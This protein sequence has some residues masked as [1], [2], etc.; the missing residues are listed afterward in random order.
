MLNVLFAA[1]FERGQ[2]LCQIDELIAF[3]TEA[4]LD[5]TDTRKAMQTGQ[6]ATVA[7]ADREPLAAPR[8]WECKHP[9]PRVPDPEVGAPGADRIT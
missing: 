2:D 4:G 6:Y 3:A 9:Q 7:A 5:T 1:F 8:P